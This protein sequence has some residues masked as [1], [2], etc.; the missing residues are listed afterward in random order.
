MIYIASDHAGFDLKTA[1]IQHISNAGYGVTDKG[2]FSTDAVDYPDYAQKVTT[3]LLAEPSAC[4]ILICGTGIGMSIAANRSPHIRAA[5]CQTAAE[6]HLA[7]AHNNANILCLGARIITKDAAALCV[8]A[9]LTAQFE[10]SKH[11]ARVQKLT[12]ISVSSDVL[13][14]FIALEKDAVAFGFDW[15]NQAMIFE[16]IISECA[17][18]QDAVQNGESPARIQEEISD[19]LHAVISLCMYSS[20]DVNETIALITQK[21]NNRMTALKALTHDRGLKT[22]HG[23][24]FEFILELWSEAKKR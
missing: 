16:Q 13:D 17:E 8:D 24:S 9:F 7:R 18:I 3:Q 22:L 5:L 15:P 11:A 10:S 20:F 12:Q 19:L 6:A 23:K 1:L 21:F 2:S 14:R 4:G